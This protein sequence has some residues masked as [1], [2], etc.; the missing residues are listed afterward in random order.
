MPEYSREVKHLRQGRGWSQEQLAAI[1]GISVRT[2]Q[3]ME[4]GKSPSD[5]S[6]KAIA[7]AF[8]RDVRMLL[9]SKYPKPDPSNSAPGI[10]PQTTNLL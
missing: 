8:E 10:A 2:I 1:A 5:E 3:R 6:L 4:K 7:N 9:Q